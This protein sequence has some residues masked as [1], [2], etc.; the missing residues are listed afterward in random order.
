MRRE[1]HRGN[2]MAVTTKDHTY[3]EWDEGSYREFYDLREDPDGWFNQV[4]SA[5]YSR[6]VSYHEKL[7][8]EHFNQHLK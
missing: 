6:E 5:E 1:F 8:H 4:N 7:L 2:G 3:M